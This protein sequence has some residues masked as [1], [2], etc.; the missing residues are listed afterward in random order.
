MIKVFL[1]KRKSNKQQTLILITV[2]NILLLLAL[3]SYISV[4]TLYL[5]GR[6]FCMSAVQVAFLA[7]TSSLIV[8]V[9]ILISALSKWRLDSTYLF[10]VIGIIASIIH[11]V[12]FAVSKTIWLLYLGL[13]SFSRHSDITAL[14]FICSCLY[15]KL[16]VPDDAGPTF[17][18]DSG[19]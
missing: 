13:P 6:P 10:P 11:H 3:V 15:W 5:Y 18:I 8:F 17:K 14:E 9:L 19:Y 2:V 1:I 12:I 7:S 16:I 4:L